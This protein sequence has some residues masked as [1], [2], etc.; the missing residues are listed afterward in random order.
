MIV[1]SS[2]MTLSLASSQRQPARQTLP[3]SVSSFGKSEYFAS[4]QLKFR[5]PVD[6][7]QVVKGLRTWPRQSWQQTLPRN[8]RKRLPSPV[9]GKYHRNN[10]NR[11]TKT[12]NQLT[13]C[14]ASS[15]S[16]SLA[17][18]WSSVITILFVKSKDH[19]LKFN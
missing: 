13:T 15:L 16:I 5:S 14:V 2:H 17:F 1:N 6:V 7:V 9:R 3:V 8:H 4:R 11:H 12:Q 18:S 19:K 10:E